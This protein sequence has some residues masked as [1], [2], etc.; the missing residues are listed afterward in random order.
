[1]NDFDKFL[2]P[3]KEWVKEAAATSG[4]GIEENFASRP[5]HPTVRVVTVRVPAAVHG[6]EPCM[7]A[8]F[9]V[10][11]EEFADVD[12]KDLIASI[13]NRWCGMM[14]SLWFLA[15]EN[16]REKIEADCRRK[17]AQYYERAAIR[18]A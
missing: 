1:M 11:A 14:Q 12:L 5:Q 16:G 13:R 6:D 4:V 17:V 15:I 3:A 10:L 9:A 2:E 18:N 8:N 7:T